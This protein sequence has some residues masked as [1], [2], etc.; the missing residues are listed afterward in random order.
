[1]IPQAIPESS[2]ANS[3]FVRTKQCVISYVIGANEAAT[4]KNP[5]DAT[6]FAC[7]EKWCCLF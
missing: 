5:Q 7:L 6:D 3:N 1:M 2:S 4:V